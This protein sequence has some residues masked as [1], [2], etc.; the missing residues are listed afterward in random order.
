MAQMDPEFQKRLNA[1]VQQFAEACQR[2]VTAIELSR[3]EMAELAAV[4]DRDLKASLEDASAAIIQQARYR[5]GK[6]GAH[7]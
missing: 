7:L 5:S 4:L 3:L 1:S 6:P 2:M